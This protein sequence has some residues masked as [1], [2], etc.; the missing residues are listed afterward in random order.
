MLIKR[1]F[2]IG[3]FLIGTN[4]YAEVKT[5]G[6]LGG[7]ETRSG[8][9]TI[10]NNLG[11]QKGGNIFHSFEKFNIKAD[12]SATFTSTTSVENIISRVT[13]RTQ[14]E[15]YGTLRS[16]IDGANLYLL[17]PNGIVFGKNARLNVTGSFHVS[18][19][20]V[21]HFEDGGHFDVTNP[22]NSLLT[23]AQPTA[24]GFLG[25]DLGQITVKEGSYLEIP[26]N[27]TLSLVGGSLLITDSLLFA[28][29]GRINLV[30][31]GNESDMQIKD[32]TLYAPSGRINL[33]ATD[34]D[35]VVV[36]TSVE[37]LA[38]K[39]FEKGG[40]ITLSD[41][42]IEERMKQ[43]G[44]MKLSP[45][46]VKHIMERKKSPSAPP[47]PLANLDVNGEGGGHVFIRAGQF[48]MESSSIFADNTSGNQDA[49][50]I[51]I[52]VEGD[53]RLTN[54]ARITSGAMEELSENVR[55]GDI[56]I[57]AGKL[58][59]SG[60]AI[61]QLSSKVSELMGYPPKFFEKF[62]MNETEASDF[63][64]NLNAV[65]S[66]LPE[67]STEISLDMIVSKMDKKYALLI[68]Q[69]FQG[70]LNTIGTLNF[71]MGSGG[72]I[73]INT[74]ILSADN[75]LIQTA[76]MGNGPAG[77]L[78]ITN[79]QQIKLNNHS[80]INA[81]TIFNSALPPFIKTGSG[82]A[83]NITLNASDSISLSN[84]S[85]ISASTSPN[86]TGNAGNINLHTNDLTMK[87][88]QIDSF[89]KGTGNAG[90][91]NI[92]TDFATLTN[93]SKIQ[94][95]AKNAGGG[96]IRL[97][98]HD[99]LL[100]ADD[101]WITA[102]AMGDKPE[103]K[104]GNIT[105]SNPQLF[106][107]G[108]DSQLLTKGFVGDG[109]NIKIG[110]G[111]FI[112]SSDSIL[113]ASSDLGV[114]GEIEIDAIEKDISLDLIGLSRHFMTANFSL[115]RCEGLANNLSSF[116]LISRDRPAES[117]TDLK[118]NPYVPSDETD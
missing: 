93:Q 27:R 37:D 62:H 67:S 66:E 32:S 10:P 54:S 11:Q 61:E 73:E 3:C 115:S 110:A 116:Y 40:T 95:R 77:D 15:I 34:S 16:E 104:G 68:P 43:L 44:S 2:I 91:I 108:K 12:E 109:G 63:L 50:G 9:F 24:F 58:E 99:N 1:F 113:D 25:N 14:S 21:L 29:N 83:G 89:S 76:T 87:L 100:M 13:G 103:A 57:Q 19:A 30:A 47:E 8:H 26:E 74:P 85:S 101:S 118:T 72:H 22:S 97:N 94:T 20:D 81:V 90:S 78:N 41:S 55:G 112:R 18:T 70:T 7:V 92:I 106:I 48:F 23:V 35:N 59:M 53:M 38:A 88:G 51:E 86:S 71:G 33:L 60:L 6:T 56:S 52:A 82:Q 65:I 46:L 96:N 117:P 79:A 98:V 107:L 80:L 4:L 31:T 42:S 75:T 5:D 49:L 84:F 45:T 36:P 39:S 105:I 64:T 102:E 28:P 69:L 114:D 111:Q 17:N